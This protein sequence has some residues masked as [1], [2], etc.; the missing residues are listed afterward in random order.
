MSS[1]VCH[2]A[3]IL[4]LFAV[5]LIKKVTLQSLCVFEQT[6]SDLIH[7]VQNTTNASAVLK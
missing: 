1:L 7:F 5:V 2:G 3:L 6:F 4:H